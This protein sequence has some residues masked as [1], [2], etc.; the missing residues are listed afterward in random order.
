MSNNE[1]QSPWDNF[2]IEELS[3]RCGCGNM[4]MDKTFMEKLVVLREAFGSPMVVSS[5]YRCP[6]HN[7]YISKTGL[8][9]PHTTGHAVDVL[10]AGEKADH[11]LGM[12]FAFGFPGKGVSQSGDWGARSIH[13]DD[14]ENAPGCPRPRTWSY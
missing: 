6:P 12:A 4:M 10:I 14:L 5:G 3:C 9:G 1:P 11:L 13:I 2:T 7:N 8:T